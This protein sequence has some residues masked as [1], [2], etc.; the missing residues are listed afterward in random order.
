MELISK[1]QSRK[2][3]V[4]WGL[5]ILS[6]FTIFKLAGYRAPKTQDIEVKTLKMLG[7]D[8]KLVEVVQSTVPANRKKIT[9]TELQKWIKK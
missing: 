3:F 1:S 7:E 4:Q 2:K 6:S 9:D 5:G 8:G